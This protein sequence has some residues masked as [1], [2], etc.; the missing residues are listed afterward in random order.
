MHGISEI[1][2][3]NEKATEEGNAEREYII[4]NRSIFAKSWSEAK[5]K[6]DKLNSVPSWSD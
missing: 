4:E 2:E 1:I 5:H 6:Y 3:A